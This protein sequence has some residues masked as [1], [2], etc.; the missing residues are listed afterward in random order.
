MY[1]KK[2]FI[3]IALFALAC[4]KSDLTGM[5]ASSDVQK[6]AFL[7]KSEQQESGDYKFVENSKPEKPSQQLKLI[8]TGSCS[9]KL[10]I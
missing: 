1:M 5:E 8:K 10:K 6:E 2:Y 3:V 4:N 7:E 9:L